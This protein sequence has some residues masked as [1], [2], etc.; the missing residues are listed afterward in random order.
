MVRNP[1]MLMMCG[2]AAAAM[3]AALGSRAMPMPADTGLSM[4]ALMPGLA[5]LGALDTRV[6]TMTSPVAGSPPAVVDH[7]SEGHRQPRASRES[8]ETLD[9]PTR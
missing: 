5:A 8:R 3:G 6:W 2:L 1:R 4:L 9:R 7:P